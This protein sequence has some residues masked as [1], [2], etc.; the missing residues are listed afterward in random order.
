M[1]DI[2][3]MIL[4]LLPVFPLFFLFFPVG[5]DIVPVH[6]SIKHN[7]PIKVIT[8]MIIIAIIAVTRHIKLCLKRLG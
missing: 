4:T 7:I 6:N 8:F 1:D 5:G 3:F 2:L